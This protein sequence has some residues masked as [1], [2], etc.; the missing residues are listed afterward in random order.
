MDELLGSSKN[1]RKIVD[2]WF[3][4]EDKLSILLSIL[5][6]RYAVGTVINRGIVARTL[7]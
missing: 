5:I 2:S 6:K 1:K 3:I 4:E 7:G